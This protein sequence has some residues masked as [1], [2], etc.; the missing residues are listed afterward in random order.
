M[1]NLAIS[2]VLSQVFPISPR[3]V[4]SKDALHSPETVA[5][6]IVEAPRNLMALNV[7]GILKTYEI[8]GKQVALSYDEKTG[9][10]AQVSDSD[11]NTVQIPQEWISGLPDSVIHDSKAMRIFL[12]N[13]HVTM[14]PLDDGGFHVYIHARMRGGGC[15]KSNDG[16]TEAELKAVN[17]LIS[18]SVTP[19]ILSEEDFKT[20]IKLLE[21]VDEKYSSTSLIT[22]IGNRAKNIS[23]TSST[24]DA[25]IPNG[26]RF[27]R[28]TRTA[29]FNTRD[30]QQNTTP[31]AAD[32]QSV[33]P[34]AADSQSGRPSS[35]RFTVSRLSSDKRF[36]EDVE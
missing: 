33:D 30:L 3:T 8:N 13:T 24:H 28:P 11:N 19:T 5:V 35:S 20:V 6:L 23:G 7:T 22:T 26:P 15:F 17:C 32:S 9:V 16:L 31:R 2:T 25:S 12:N 34:R 14:N 4:N 1:S 21:F 29:P 10:T 27:S 18:K 36:V